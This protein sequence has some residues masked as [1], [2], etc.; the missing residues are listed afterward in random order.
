MSSPH[1]VDEGLAAL[2]GEVT[3]DDD[4]ER[5]HRLAGHED[6]SVQGSVCLHDGGHVITRRC[7]LPQR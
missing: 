1:L 5:V 6:V 7:V 2:V 3:V 4:A